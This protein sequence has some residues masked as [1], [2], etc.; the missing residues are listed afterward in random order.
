[1]DKFTW[2]QS[3]LKDLEK[4]IT[5]PARWKA[6]WIDKLFKS[7]TSEAADYGNYFEYLCIGG[8]AHGDAVTDL[9]RTTTGAK[10]ATQKRIEA[11]AELF[12]EMMDRSS[13]KYL[14]YEIQST[15][16]KLRGY[17]GNCYVEGVADIITALVGDKSCIVDLKLTEDLDNVRTE[18]GWGNATEDID[19]LQQVLYQELYF[20]MYGVKPPMHLLVFE[21][22]LKQR[23]KVIKLNISDKKVQDCFER[24]EAGSEVVDM[25]NATKWSKIPSNQECK[26]CKL[27]C[28][29]RFKVQQIIHE[30]INY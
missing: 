2:S 24:F 28:D 6:Q 13:E 22:G 1:M 26:N 30:E 17:I 29:K 3:A 4:T 15:Q 12:K 20:Q 23:V 16:T 5:C 10:T 25:Y 19:L 8:S 9:P 7:F 14:G 18:Y 27:E 21:H 11:Q